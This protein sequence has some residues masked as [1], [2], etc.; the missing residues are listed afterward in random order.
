M[1]PADAVET[2]RAAD[3]W[4]DIKMRIISKDAQREWDVETPVLSTIGASQFENVMSLKLSG[5]INSDDI[6]Y[7]RNKM[8]NLHHL[9]LKDA[10]FIDSD[11]EYMSGAS[12]HA[13]K[14]GGFQSLNQLLSIVLPT[15]AKAIEASAFYSCGNLKAVTIQ[16]GVESIEGLAFYCCY[17]LKSIGLHS[18]LKSIGNNAFYYCSNMSS[19][20]FPP[21]LITIESG[22]FLHNNLSEISNT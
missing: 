5:D 13:D 11:K 10:N 2:Y 7:I 12:T 8:F 20:S 15:S 14:V 22:A 19:L 9:D 17:A 16:E 6:M 4:K 3:Y 1:V 21:G 18:S